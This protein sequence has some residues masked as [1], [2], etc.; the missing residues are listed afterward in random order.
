MKMFNLPAP[1]LATALAVFS[2]TGCQQTD[3]GQN[4]AGINANSKP[5]SEKI[6]EAAIEAELLRIQ[7]DWP[8]AVKEKDVEALRRLQADDIVIIYP[9]GTV[10]T[11]EQEIKDIESGDFTVDSWEMTDLQVK[12]INATAAGV[13]GRS[14]V[15][16][17]YKAGDGAL[18]EIDGQYRFANTYVRRNGEW[19]LLV[20][21]SAQLVKPLAET[22]PPETKSP[23]EA[24]SPSPTPAE[25]PNP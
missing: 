9:D 15:K 8:R 4:A 25:S 10:G 16:G 2:L 23:P 5:E 6:N 19:K 17:K 3:P 21:A 13:V 18:S 24:I 12:I 14:I 7:R 20:S 1:A 11:K 22:P